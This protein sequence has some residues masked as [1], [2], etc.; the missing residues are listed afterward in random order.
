MTSDHLRVSALVYA[1]IAASV[2]VFLYRQ[3]IKK[4]FLDT[5]LHI[6]ATVTF[7]ALV[8]GLNGGNELKFLAGLLLTSAASVVLGIRFR[9]FAFVVYGIVFGYLGLTIEVL[10]N[11]RGF[12]TVLLYIVVTGSGVILLVVLLA[13]RFGREE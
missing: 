8:S 13:R 9:K 12:S 1:S 7:I 6:A 3:G 4:H 5:Y 10:Q 2:G 11:V